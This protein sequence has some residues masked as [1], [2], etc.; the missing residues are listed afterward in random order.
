[1]DSAGLR[2]WGKLTITEYDEQVPR[3]VVTLANS[4]V[5]EEIG[6][7]GRM[8]C[9]HLPGSIAERS[10]PFWPREEAVPGKVTG[11]ETRCLANGD[12][13]CVFEI[14]AVD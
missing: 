8:V 2:G 7:A 4:A 9:D 14:T 5:A 11:R 6:H 12:D 3:V 13:M 1:M 10:R